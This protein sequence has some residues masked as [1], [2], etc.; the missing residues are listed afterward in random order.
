MPSSE[1]IWSIVPKRSRRAGE[2]TA[3]AEVL[4]D[5]EVREE[6]AFLKDVADAATMRRQRDLGLGVEQDHVADANATFVRPDQPGHC[7][8]HGRLACPGTAEERGDP[9]GCRESD[10]ERERA[11][12][13]AD[14]DLDT[15][16]SAIQRAMRRLTSSETRSAPTATTTET[17]ASRSAPDS[18]PGTC[19][20]A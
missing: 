7:V 18:P 13:V 9:G 8:D 2:P 3:E 11:L 6:P 17:R 20:S 10:V 19:S 1:T 12:P 15:H 16:R 14:L 4:T 5:R